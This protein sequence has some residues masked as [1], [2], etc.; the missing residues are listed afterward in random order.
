M[1]AGLSISGSPQP[2]RQGVADA[3]PTLR[4]PHIHRRTASTVVGE[5]PQ[6][7]HKSRRSHPPSPGAPRRAAPRAGRSER[8]GEAYAFQYVEALNDAR[9]TL[10][11]FVSSLLTAAYHAANDPYADPEQDVAG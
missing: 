11:D 4:I 2:H 3:R 9:T 1:G 10:A 5:G 7:A 8:R 6:A